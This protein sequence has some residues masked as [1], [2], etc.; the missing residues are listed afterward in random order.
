MNRATAPGPACTRRAFLGGATLCMGGVALGA[1]PARPVRTVSILHTTDLHG[2][3]RPTVSY[4]GLG[5]LGGLARCATQLRAW[6]RENPDSLLVDVGDVW[7]GTEVGH[8]T[9]GE[10]M[11]RLFAA[12]GYDAWVPGNHDFDWGREVFERAVAGS[13]MP[14][15]GANLRIEGARQGE[16]AW[17]RW[18]PWV[19][20]EVGGFR[21]GLVGL[22]T[23]GLPWWLAPETLA[24]ISAVDPAEA[25]Q[26]A[27]DA[28][29]ER[30]PD[31]VVVLGHMGWRFQDDFAN[32]VRELLRKVRGVDV[33]LA[34]HSHQD[35]PSWSL[36]GVL[37]SQA[38]YH[39]IHCGRVDL[40]FDA[41]SRQLVDRRA[42]TVLMDARF[43]EDPAV[44]QAAGEDLA[45]SER[46]L[47]RPLCEVRQPLAGRG[48]GSALVRLFCEAFRSALQRAGHA[49]DGVFHGTFGSGEVA[50]GPVTLAD[51]W[52][53]IPYEN[54]LVVAELTGEQLV[55]VVA[56]DA[57]DPRSDRTLWPFEVEWGGDGKLRR[58]A[59]GGVEV[60]DLQ[61]RFRIAVNS[62]DAQSAG[63]RLM[64]LREL[65]AA[66]A[67]RRQVVQVDTRGALVGHLLEKG[68]L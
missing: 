6:R 60:A 1:R 67:A 31:A 43:A 37:C 33:Y 9:R 57:K 29:R 35:Q 22:T 66:P 41:G 64:R 13:A 49:V 14:V 39:G 7:Q 54:L 56:E 18:L 62:Y 25:L 28:M 47:A 23:P 32:P 46:E 51:V 8:A 59:H 40:T 3:I 11:T 42:F 16:G 65:L 38:N 2:H 34:G 17:S 55:E 61:R 52:E 53:W 4:D 30:K 5:G 24:G 63:R 50:A 19:V 48:R 12:L 26:A 21:I 68:V 44:L 45:R 20:K 58:L 36:H 15:L 10:A 27:L